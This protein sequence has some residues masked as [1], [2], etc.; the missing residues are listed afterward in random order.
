MEHRNNDVQSSWPWFRGRLAAPFWESCLEKLL[1]T[2]EEQKRAQTWKK[3]LEPP[4]QCLQDC[5]VTQ[6]YMFRGAS[7]A[8][9][10]TEV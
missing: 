10:N 6:P 2:R 1:T 3:Q 9:D 8:I 7:Q 5:K 4:W